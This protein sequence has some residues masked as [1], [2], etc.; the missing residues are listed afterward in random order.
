MSPS[1]VVGMSELWCEARRRAV[2][3]MYLVLLLWKPT[4]W[5]RALRVGAGTARMPSR[6][7]PGG[8]GRDVW[9]F[10]MARAVV[11]SLVW[12]ESMRAM[13]VWKRRSCDKL[14]LRIWHGG[15][16]SRLYI[17][18]RDAYAR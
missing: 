8:E 7:K 13:R 10:E 12:D 3:F 17:S 18:M 15:K 11:V 6:V 4:G 5:M 1:M 16:S 9:R 14:V 2:A